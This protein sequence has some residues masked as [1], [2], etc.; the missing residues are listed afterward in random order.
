MDPTTGRPMCLVRW[1]EKEK[2]VET[3]RVLATAREL[4]SAAASAEADVAI[5]ES[6]RSW[7]LPDQAIAAVIMQAREL[8]GK[9]RLPEGVKPVFRIAAIAGANTG[10]PLVSISLGSREV[11]MDTQG[12]REL[13]SDWYQVGMASILDVRIRYTLADHGFDVV[14]VEE[15]MSDLSR[16]NPRGGAGER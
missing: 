13:A 3:E 6:F 10:L 1:V 11:T 2:V 16:L 7:D 4:F 15:F 12:A 9:Q 8:R 14:A 5:L